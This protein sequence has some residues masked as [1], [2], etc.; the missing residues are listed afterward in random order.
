MLRFQDPLSTWG[1]GATSRA[2]MILAENGWLSVPYPWAC[3][4]D[5]T[6]SPTGWALKIPTGIG[7]DGNLRLSFGGALQTFGMA[8]RFW[9]SNLPS[10]PESIFRFSQ[11][12]GVEQVKI[13]LN[14]DGSVYAVNGNGTLL[15]TSSA[16]R[17]TPGSFT[18]IETR[19]KIAASPSGELEIRINKRVALNLTGIATKNSSG[20]NDAAYVE[21]MPS[22]V[23]RV[24]AALGNVYVATPIVW[25]ESGSFCNTFLGPKVPYLVALTSD[26]TPTDWDKI[27]GAGSSYASV[28]AIPQNGASVYLEA[29]VSGD[30][31]K[32]NFAATSLSN[33]VALTIQH[34]DRLATAGGST[35]TAS[36]FSGGSATAGTDRNPSY[37][38]WTAY[39]DTFYEDPASSGA[40]SLTAPLAAGSLGAKLERTA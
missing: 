36:L 2:N 10:V 7:Y 32:M 26:G 4:D 24:P 39:Q 37:P 29:T 23:Y 34:T 8:Y 14:P 31:T 3:T 28:S 35:M 33:V 1:S 11:N 19:V 12:S 15:G 30:V 21:F 13:A 17:V 18:H 5:N 9:A 27:G 6:L 22:N 40:G 16:G 38:A 20:G 25:D